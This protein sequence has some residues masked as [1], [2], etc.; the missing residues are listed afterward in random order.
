M[1]VVFSW[2]TP[3]IDTGN[4]ADDLSV[5]DTSHKVADWGETTSSGTSS[6][7]DIEPLFCHTDTTNMRHG[8]FETLAGRACDGAASKCDDHVCVAREL[9]SPFCSCRDWDHGDFA[10]SHCCSSVE[11]FDSL[12]AAAL[13]GPLINSGCSSESWGDW[14][15]S[16]DGTESAKCKAKPRL[17]TGGS[18]GD[19]F[20]VEHN[21]ANDTLNVKWSPVSRFAF[22]VA[23]LSESGKMANHFGVSTEI[24]PV[25]VGKYLTAEG[26]KV[27]CKTFHDCFI[28]DTTL[29]SHASCFE[30]PGA[31]ELGT[32]RADD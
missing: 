3:D 31:L 13:A 22:A 28:R 32:T 24:D 17:A 4:D 23:A 21:T 16:S 20:C 1:F 8:H 27:H 25:R 5:S 26:H 15:L 7:K 6:S 12:A 14:H 11:S 10:I 29:A 2:A 18:P 9:G 19:K 30:T